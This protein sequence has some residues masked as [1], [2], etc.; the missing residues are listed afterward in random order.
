MKINKVETF[1]SNA[2]LRNYLFV[3]L[4]TDS[5]LRGVGEA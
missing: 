2:G 4:H 5:G 3:R 1:L